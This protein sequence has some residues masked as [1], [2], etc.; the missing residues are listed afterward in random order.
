MVDVIKDRHARRGMRAVAAIAAVVGSLGLTAAA[1]AQFGSA[2]GFGE[3][4]TPYFLRRDLTLFADGLDLD[5]GQSMIVE[6]LYWDYEDEH[7]AGKSRM[8]ERLG[9][10]R[11]ELKNLDR[12][13]V[14]ELVFKPFEERSTEWETM[15]ERFVEN[16][17]AV[18]TSEQ[19]ERWPKFRRRLRRD[20][21]LP[22]GRLSG[23]SA[24]LF[25]LVAE[26]D[27]DERTAMHIEPEL[28]EYDLTLDGALLVREKHMHDSRLAMINSLRD[29]DTDTSLA[30]YERQIVARLAIRDTNDTFTEI[31]ADALPSDVGEEFRTMTYARAYPRVYRAIAAQRI[32]TE[33]RQLEDLSAETLDAIVELEDAFL[34]ELTPLNERI[35]HLIQQHEPAE[36]RYRAASFAARASGVRKPKP[37]DPTR[38]E[39]RR[40]EELGRTYVSLLR[41]LLTPEQ[42]A[43][44]SGSQ[45]F[46]GRTVGGKSAGSDAT[47]SRDRSEKRRLIEQMRHP[48]LGASKRAGDDN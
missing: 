18:L 41:D 24:N 12:D 9:N 21:E 14:L 13:Q 37:A 6:S 33:A 26:L 43:S 25:H 39:F 4:M 17:K 3:M 45:R 40:R 11:D 32:F 8:I 44:L 1:P 15:R 34:D 47:G 29:E 35:R 10:M 48:S 19:L 7:E 42:F 2:A 16:V 28:D 5:E 27:L 36:S 22:K 30:I 38:P 46:L 23:E 20:K 31:I